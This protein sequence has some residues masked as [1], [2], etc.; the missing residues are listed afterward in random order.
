MTKVLDMQ[1]IRYANIFDKVTNIRTNHCFE[2]NNNII[3]AVPRVFVMRAIGMDNCNLRRLSDII[4]KR[5]KIVAIPN[6]KEDM[7]SFISVVTHPVKFK[8]VEIKDGEVI[9]NA[10]SQSRASLIG[11]DKRRLKEMENIIEQYFG[12]KRLR[13]K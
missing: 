3:F 2:Y 6:G 13:I 5:V 8:A 1:F 11:R 12:I 9:I 10:S 4:G 7:E